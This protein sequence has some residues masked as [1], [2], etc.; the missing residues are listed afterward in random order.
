LPNYKNPCWFEEV[1]PSTVYNN[2]VYAYFKDK[3]HRIRP[4][5]ERFKNTLGKRAK[6]EGSAWLL[7]CLPYFFLVGA[8]RCGTTDLYSKMILHPEIPHQIG[9]EPVYWNRARYLSEFGLIFF[10]KEGLPMSVLQ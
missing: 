9:K 6:R 4:A 10:K 2:N 7:R 8:P 5:F 1:D 3:D